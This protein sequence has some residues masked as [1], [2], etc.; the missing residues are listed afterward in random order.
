MN[1][2]VSAPVTSLIPLQESSVILSQATSKFRKRKA[3]Q[4]SPSKSPEQSEIDFLKLELNSVRTS[5]IE[6]ESAKIDLERK[7][8]IMTEVI[9]MHEQRQA[10]KAYSDIR[11]DATNLNQSQQYHQQQQHFVSHCQPSYHPCHPNL[12]CN[13]SPCHLRRCCCEDGKKTVPPTDTNVSSLND[14]YND[15]K[16]SVTSIQ[17]DIVDIVNKI[18]SFT[19]NSKVK[20]NSNLPVYRNPTDVPD[21]DAIEILAE[22]EVHA[23]PTEDSVV[24][25]DE[26]VP[27]I[28]MECDQNNLLPVSL[29]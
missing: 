28:P 10:A 18:D 8:K 2:A 12:S 26:F 16:A 3:N 22:V 19:D 20:K 11:T 6:L 25:I 29:N 14:L 13:F 4:K 24:S 5:V 15:L 9:K 1:N 17:D 21:Y 7:V 23:A 27:D